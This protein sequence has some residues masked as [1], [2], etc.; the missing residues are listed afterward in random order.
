MR[1]IWYT[2]AFLITLYWALG[3]FV[4]DLGFLVHA[5]LGM[6]IL[7]FIAGTQ[8]HRRIA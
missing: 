3:A 5:M 7:S 2:V 6:A 1:N 8:N 4:W